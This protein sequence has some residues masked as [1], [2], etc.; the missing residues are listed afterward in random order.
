VLADEPERARPPQA[1]ADFRSERDFWQLSYGH[2]TGILAGATRV[3]WH[4]SARRLGRG[5]SKTIG[6][7]QG[8][9]LRRTGVANIG[10]IACRLERCDISWVGGVGRH[11]FE[12][13][14]SARHSTANEIMRDL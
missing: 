10:A 9:A 3:H 7:P 12:K 8:G 1:R 2:R 11:G 13:M 14:L 4:A 5:F 6:Q